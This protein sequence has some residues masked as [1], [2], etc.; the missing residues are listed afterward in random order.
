MSD[1]ATTIA[2]LREN[3]AAFVAERDWQQFH[4]PKNLAMS[5]AIEAAELMEHFQWISAEES[6]RLPEDPEKLG[7]IGEEMAD[8]LCYLLALANELEIDLSA[9]FFDKMGKN[10]EK[11]P[12]AEYRGRYGADDPNEATRSG[13]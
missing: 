11:Y 12:A 3:V 1:Q 5:L 9:A 4:A 13:D 10:A 6:R 7:P 8:V 2:E